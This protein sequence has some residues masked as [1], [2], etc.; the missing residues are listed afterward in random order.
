[1]T[2][3]VNG[4]VATDG[5]FPWMVKMR[6][7]NPAGAGLCG[8]SLINE[9]WVLTA[10]HCFYDRGGSTPVVTSVDLQFGCASGKCPTTIT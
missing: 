8:G 1:M 10:A 6:L 3:I 5:E 7:Q 4:A 9:N 2:R